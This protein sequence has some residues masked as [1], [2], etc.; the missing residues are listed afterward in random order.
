MISLV[1]FDIGW[2]PVKASQ[3]WRPG[4]GRSQLR[5]AIASNKNRPSRADAP[6]EAT[7][8]AKAR[9]AS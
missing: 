4:P 1:A 7:H 8:Q 5:R 9:D 6:F 3:S 2:I